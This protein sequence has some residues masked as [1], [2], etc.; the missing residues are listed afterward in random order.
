M[1]FKLFW[2]FCQLSKFSERKRLNAYLIKP[3]WMQLRHSNVC[4]KPYVLQRITLNVPFWLKT[5]LRPGIMNWMA[6]GTGI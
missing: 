3:K 2:E 6:D 5:E 1:T 4:I